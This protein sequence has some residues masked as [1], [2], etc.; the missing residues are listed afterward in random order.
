LAGAIPLPFMGAYNATK[1]AVIALSETLHAELA[2]EGIGV[3]VLCPSFTRTG[4]VDAA[5]GPAPAATM[6]LARQILRHLGS[7]P[8]E[9]AALGLDASRR[10]QLYAMPTHHGR[11]AWR[12]KRL[13]PSSLTRALGLAHRWASRGRGPKAGP[14]VV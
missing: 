9:V 1:A 7:T 6:D 2:A 8:E 13:A 12:A 11:L 3:T 14:R 5:S 10:G 4:F